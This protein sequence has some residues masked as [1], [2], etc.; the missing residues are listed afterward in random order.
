ML[1]QK[2]KKWNKNDSKNFIKLEQA[3]VNL[4]QVLYT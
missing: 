1:L 2:S 4:P 3:K